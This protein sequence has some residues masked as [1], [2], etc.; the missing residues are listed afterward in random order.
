MGNICN[1]FRQTD[2]RAIPRTEDRFFKIRVFFQICYLRNFFAFLTKVTRN[3][4]A[5]KAL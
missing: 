4:A 3:L 5:A 1:I 2:I